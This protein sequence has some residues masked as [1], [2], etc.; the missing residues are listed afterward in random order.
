MDCRTKKRDANQRTAQDNKI[1][2]TRVGELVHSDVCGPFSTQDS[3]GNK[4]FVTLI[5]DFSRFVMARAIQNKSD[6]EQNLQELIALFETMSGSK[7]ANLRCDYGGEYQSKSL[8]SWLRRKGIDAKPT[9]PYH[10][11]TNAVAERANRTIVTNIRAN[12][13]ELPKSLWSLAMSYSIYMRNRLP[14]ATLA[15]KCPLEIIRR[16]V[17][18][19]IERKM[20]RKFGEKVYI[21]TYDDGK[22][23]DRATKA[24]I[25]RYTN[26]NGTYLVMMENRRVTTAKNPRVRTE[27]TPRIIEAAGSPTILADKP[28]A[29]EIS[30]VPSP[31]VAAEVPASVTHE[32]VPEKQQ[33]VELRRSQRSTA[34]KASIRLGEDP[35][36]TGETYLTIAQALE[37]TKSHLWKE[38]M[39]RELA[40]LD[41]YG[42]YKW[43]DAVP[44]GGK[45]IDTKWVVREKEEKAVSD[46]KRYKARLTARGF[47]Q[48]AGIDYHDTY[49][50]VC[51]AESWRLLICCGLKDRM[52]IRQYDIERAFLNG[53][54]QEEL[55]VKDTHATGD[56]AWKLVK[57][58]Y[59]TKQAAHNWNRVIDDILVGL[60]FIQS[61][62]DPGL[63]F[64]IQDGSII[65][66]HVD[67]LLCAFRTHKIRE[68]WEAELK[69]HLTV[70]EKGLPSRFLGMDITW[71]QEGAKVTGAPAIQSLANMWQ[72]TKESD[73]PF[74]T[75]IEDDT[76]A[77]T[78]SFQAMVGSLLF[79]ARMWRP[80]IRYAVN[81]LCMKA[82]KPNITDVRRGCRIISYLLET[83]DEGITLRELCNSLDIFTDAGE[84]NLEEKATTGV[85]V[86]CGRSPLGWTARKQDVTTLSPTEAEYIALGVGAQDAM[87]LRKILGFLNRPIVPRVWTDNHGASTLAYNPDFHKRTKHIRRRHHFVRECG[88]ITVHWVPGEENPADMLTKPVT[89]ARLAALKKITGM[90]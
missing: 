8:I 66:I 44:A 77:D 41:K 23:A 59:G 26:T 37:S 51:R 53:P 2:T 89:G 65:T 81:R 16:G 78:K 9:V 28:I 46:P 84:E 30:S 13:G 71:S 49:A 57:S 45:I 32:P 58:L 83:Q 69:K 50:P 15:G 70:E 22:L 56:K 3:R 31:I 87:W 90:I 7:I 68:A 18:L 80:D 73:I 17:D 62:D 64:H 33:Y 6:V 74:L 47:T 4:Y 72:V 76:P 48:R 12:L 61:P 20:F 40:L 54:L 29:P 34:G 35:R 79:I 82:S 19:V 24:I 60:G 86:I 55:Y 14:H 1:R 38:A 43:I 67:D 39:Q 36:Y 88:D 21:P 27:Q 52:V 63:Y 11:E 42:V 10:S 25:V 5:D 75:T 85:L